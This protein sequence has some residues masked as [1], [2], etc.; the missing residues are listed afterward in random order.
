[1]GL[2]DRKKLL[3]KQLL[4]VVKVEL[5]NDEFVYVRQ[6]TGR[7]RDRFEL[8]L[9]KDIKDDKGNV[10]DVESD[11]EDFRA[12][13]AV[14][15]IC[16]E[17]GELILRSEDFPVLSQH[18]GIQQ[19]DKIVKAAQKLNRITKADKEALTKNSGGGQAADSNSDSAKS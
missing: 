4:E 12:K 2:L 19:L 17:N 11:L 8:T 10:V 3:A 1:M 14:Q 18:M 13:L 5:D 7:E 9:N 15:T 16:D 6:M